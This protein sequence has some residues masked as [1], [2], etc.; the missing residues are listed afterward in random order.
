M[1]KV[2][3][4]DPR[5]IVSE[6]KDGANV[7]AWHWQERDLS[8][9]THEQLKLAYANLCI[10]DADTKSDDGVQS[11]QID[12]VSEI[13]GDTTV[14][15][16][17]GKMMCYFELKIKLAWSAKVSGR[18]KE[19]K[20]ALEVYE[21]DHDTFRDSYDI[22]VTCQDNDASARRVEELVRSKGRAAV[23]HVIVTYYDKLFEEYHIGQVLKSGTKMP[24]PPTSSPAPPPANSS[25]SSQANRT[26]SCSS[27]A[28][29]TEDAG[30]SSFSWK[31]RWRA[32]IDELFACLTDER[33]VSLYTRRPAQIDARAGGQFSH[34]SNVISGYFVDVQA[35]TTMKLQWR[36]ASW[37]A[38]VHSSVVMQ[39]TK[40]QPDVTLL[41]FAQCGIPSGQLA[42][43]Q[44]GWRA[45]FFN[46]IRAL[47]GFSVDYI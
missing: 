28:P 13:S 34:L 24:P 23:R 41:D 1:A 3:E 8:K 4:G 19:V 31:M 15:Q 20:G 45:N 26:S 47:Y 9:H 35:P 17:K 37:P 12:E 39:L 22:G 2:G 38:G 11:L 6:R 30:Q 16:R 27:S 42:S 46:A 44:E 40:E 18:D 33:R 25:S 36:L 29:S 21:V 43:V 14:A 32:P 7:N 5:W 10:V